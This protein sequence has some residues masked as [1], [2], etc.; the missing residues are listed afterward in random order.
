MKRNMGIANLGGADGQRLTRAAFAVMIKFSD[1]TE[2]LLNA[3]STIDLELEDR[4][5][6]DMNAAQKANVLIQILKE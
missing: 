1:L 3:I 2:E 5:E 6:D 4:L